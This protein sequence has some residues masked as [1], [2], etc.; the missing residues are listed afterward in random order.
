MCV[1][2]NKGFNAT[3]SKGVDA[4][5]SKGVDTTGSKG[6]NATG[7]KGVNA[8]GSKGVNANDRGSSSSTTIFNIDDRKQK[9]SIRNRR[10]RNNNETAEYR[11]AITS[12][13][14]GYLG[15]VAAIGAGD[16]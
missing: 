6:V 13:G 2:F 4:T 8:T 3:C 1:W 10:V 5:C 9:K 7:S 11:D 14:E 12:S 15:R 16:V